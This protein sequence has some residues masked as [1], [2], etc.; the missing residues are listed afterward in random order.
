[1]SGGLIK[2]DAGAL[3]GLE[4][5]IARLHD[6][7]F[8]SVATPLT[9]APSVDAAYDDFCGKWDKHRKEMF[10]RLDQIE[11]LLRAVREAFTQQDEQLAQAVLKGSS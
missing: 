3:S 11:G 1:M 9:G 4:G 2:I 5:R 7:V 8:E 6:N 10:Q